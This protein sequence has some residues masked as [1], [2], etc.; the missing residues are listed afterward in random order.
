MCSTFLLKVE[1]WFHERREQRQATIDV[2]DI[3]SE[4]EEEEE[5]NISDDEERKE[6]F[7]AVKEQ[8]RKLREVKESESERKF[9]RNVETKR[10]NPELE[11][12]KTQVAKLTKDLEKKNEKERDAVEWKAKHES[13]GKVLEEKEIEVKNLRTM[14]EA[15]S[16]RSDKE[17]EAN[18]WKPRYDD[19]MKTI[20]E[21]DATIDNLETMNETLDKSQGEIIKALK[22][23]LAVEAK[24]LIEHEN[25]A[26][27]LKQEKER[28]NASLQQKTQKLTE[29]EER[30]KVLS[31]EKVPEMMAKFREKLERKEEEVAKMKAEI[32][33][34]REVE[35]NL[36]KRVEQTDLEN[37]D[38]EQKLLEVRKVMI[39]KDGMIA[40]ARKSKE[41]ESKLARLRFQILDLKDEMLLQKKDQEL[42]IADTEKLIKEVVNLKSEIKTKD[43]LLQSKTT[44]SAEFKDIQM[45][46]MN[47]MKSQKKVIM[48]AENQEKII[49]NQKMMLTQLKQQ[50][51]THLAQISR[52]TEVQRISL[53]NTPTPEASLL[54]RE[55]KR[56]TD[57]LTQMRAELLR[58]Q[59]TNKD[60]TSMT[61]A[62]PH[63]AMAGF[64][65][66]G[67]EEAVKEYER[68]VNKAKDAEEVDEVEIVNLEEEVVCQPDIYPYGEE[69][70][71]D[72]TNTVISE[73]ENVLKNSATV[74]NSEQWNALW[75]KS[76]TKEGSGANLQNDITH[77]LTN[78]L[79]TK[80]KVEVQPET[81]PP[82]EVLR[83]SFNKE[84]D[85][86]RQCN[87]CGRVFLD[88]NYLKKH[89]TKAHMVDLYKRPPSPA[90][91]TH[92]S[93]KQERPTVQSL[94]SESN[95]KRRH[96]E[97]E[98]SKEQT[99]TIGVDQ[100]G[101]PLKRVRLVGKSESFSET[102]G[103]VV[104]SILD[105]L[106]YNL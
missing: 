87:I 8:R 29:T 24:E 69:D 15:L 14:N 13:I 71:S 62:G 51:Q 30:L 97:D 34:H 11:A 88:E 36:A 70:L 99:D 9:S 31:S 95:S 6:K 106:I 3:E 10:S 105:T 20:E 22:M 98:S 102:S 56:R 16:K 82:V 57:Q 37:K 44:E 35:G 96:P 55:L 103:A 32:D 73:A 23:K 94:R 104:M 85:G 53:N 7:P 17:R 100:N 38:L 33:L 4:G 74:L 45:N 92:T 19:A 43:G 41:S 86:S 48:K 81:T 2:V 93:Q 83:G 60:S 89:Q 61:K 52:L 50:S 25:C 12:L 28:A 46:M 59:Q 80:D 42:I 72:N 47:A 75:L 54:K 26:M 66:I 18:V 64:Q 76:N 79:G 40:K 84:L 78:E 68:I 5:E 39:E 65:T 77:E 1:Q 63:L 101:G 49:E 91:I 67:I 90:V 21:R 27:V 58:A